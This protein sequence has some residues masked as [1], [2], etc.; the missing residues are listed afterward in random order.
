M[1]G[2][3]QSP[4][5]ISVPQVPSCHFEG[6][7]RLQLAAQLNPESPYKSAYTVKEQNKLEPIQYVYCICFSVLLDKN[8]HLPMT[9]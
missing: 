2:T 5:Y 7:K 8:I 4:P 1:S 6:H 3:L 9:Q